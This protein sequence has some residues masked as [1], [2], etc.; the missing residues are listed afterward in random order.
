M[1]KYRFIG[2]IEDVTPCGNMD[3]GCIAVGCKGKVW[4][5]CHFDPLQ[6][7]A[8]Q[9]AS[10]LPHGVTSSMLP[11]KRYIF[12]PFHLTVYCYKCKNKK[13]TKRNAKEERG[14]VY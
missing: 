11:T 3:E 6:P 1:K 10:I 4:G 8:I 12:I 14:N 5:Q 2:N 13:V 9:S 7:A